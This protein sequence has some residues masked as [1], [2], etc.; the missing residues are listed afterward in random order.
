MVT[1]G[2]DRFVGERLI[3]AFA[4]ALAGVPLARARKELLAFG[5]RVPEPL[6]RRATRR[7]PRRPV[8]GGGGVAERVV[9]ALAA[10]SIR[11]L[12]E[13]ALGHASQA[14]LLANLLFGFPVVRGGLLRHAAAGSSAIARGAARVLGRPPN[15][16][17]RAAGR[18]HATRR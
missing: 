18:G 4:D 8:G 16:E 1:R 6:W 11:A 13:G 7:G 10:E 9:R 3:A 17:A 14:D 15:Q 12:D 2:R 5:F